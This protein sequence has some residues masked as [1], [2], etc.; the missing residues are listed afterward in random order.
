M[1]HTGKQKEAPESS[2]IETNRRK[3]EGEEE[4]NRQRWRGRA[5]NREGEKGGRRKFTDVR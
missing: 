5:S 1:L 3:R 4:R 2:V